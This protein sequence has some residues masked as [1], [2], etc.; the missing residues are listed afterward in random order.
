MSKELSLIL[1]LRSPQSNREGEPALN[2]CVCRQSAMV[3]KGN[4]HG[5]GTAAVQWGESTL[6]G[7]AQRDVLQSGNVL[8]AIGQPPA[9][10]AAERVERGQ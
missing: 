7:V 2:K 1:A 3:S 8:S 5:D 10:V 6:S 4:G 9:T